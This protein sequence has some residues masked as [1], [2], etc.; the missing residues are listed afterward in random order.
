MQ[1]FGVKQVI[2][3]GLLE[4]ITCWASICLSLQSHETTTKKSCMHE[5]WIWDLTSTR[6]RTTIEHLRDRTVT[7]YSQHL[8]CQSH[9]TQWEHCS[10]MGGDCKILH[11]LKG[12]EWHFICSEFLLIM[13]RL[14]EKVGQYLHRGSLHR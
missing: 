12:Q 10:N 5:R 6:E 8:R 9:G 14:L 13:G 11:W 7:L 2:S 3:K 4:I 1:T